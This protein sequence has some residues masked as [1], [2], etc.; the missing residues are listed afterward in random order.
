MP[1]PSNDLKARRD[2][3]HVTGCV[4]VPDWLAHHELI[5]AI[6]RCVAARQTAAGLPLGLALDGHVRSGK[7]LLSFPAFHF[8]HARRNHDKSISR[9][10]LRR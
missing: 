8:N 3:H 7:K 4:F 6:N 2:R 10:L 5:L 1:T 9:H